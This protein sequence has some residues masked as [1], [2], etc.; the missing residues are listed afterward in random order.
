MPRLDREARAGLLFVLPWLIFLLVFTA[1]PV[2]GTFSLS[3]TDYSV[4]EPPNWI[5]LD[6]YQ[7]MFSEDPA[8]WTAV[9]NSAFYAAVSVPLR[10]V[11]ACCWRCPQ[12][13]RARH[14]GLPGHLLP[15]GARAAGGRHDHL[16]ADVQPRHGP[17]NIVCARSG[18]RRPTGCAIRSGP[19]RR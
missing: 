19:S 11:L 9:K 18:C 6:N 14:L 5:G 4:L 10:L 17:I 1:Y 12:P 8:F 2:L 3:F 15:A 13:R 16:H 7:R